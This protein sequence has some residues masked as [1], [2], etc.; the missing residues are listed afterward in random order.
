M[1]V[2]MSKYDALGMLTLEYY[3]NKQ[4]YTLGNQA[5]ILEK[6]K[7]AMLFCYLHGVITEEQMITI[8][9]KFKKKFEEALYE[10]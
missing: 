7:D 6:L 2:D 10:C 4:G 5:E 8:K 1:K 9:K 3:V